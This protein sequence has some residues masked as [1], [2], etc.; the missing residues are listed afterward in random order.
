MK[1]AL[2]ILHVGEFAGPTIRARRLYPEMARRYRMAYALPP[3]G[4]ED[5]DMLLLRL[6]APLIV[7]SPLRLL[8]GQLRCAGYLLRREEFREA[9][10]V[11]VDSVYPLLPVLLARAS[12]KP[13]LMVLNDTHLDPTAARLLARLYRM[14]G[15]RFLI[16]GPGLGAHY[17]MPELDAARA[18]E[19]IFPAVDPRFFELR[20]RPDA[21]RPRRGPLRIGLVA[22][23]NRIKRQGLLLPL[24]RRLED[25]GVDHRFA[26]AGVATPGKNARMK[27]A[28]F[29]DAAAMG[30]ADRFEDHG[31]VHGAWAEALRV[32]AVV[33]LSSSEACP[34]VLLESAV[35]GIPFFS[36]DVGAVGV[37]REL[38]AHPASEVAPR[39]ADDEALLEAAARWVEGLAARLD[40]LRAAPEVGSEEATDPQALLS[41]AAVARQWLALLEPA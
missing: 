11:I 10:V 25:L 1:R 12:R 4:F 15:L 38:C 26:L 36:P 31:F 21:F 2:E 39:G 27:E 29:R 24:S 34:Q 40:E 30:L 32:D 7:Q 16:E 35:L 13:V 8:G 18:E 19:A 20:L 37:F 6:P 33:L 5:G 22:N 17:G 9:S 23:W 28:F 41:P 14:M 3:G